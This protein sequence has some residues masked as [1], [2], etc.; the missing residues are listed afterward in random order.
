MPS[1]EEARRKAWKIVSTAA[2]GAAA[3]GW[4]PGSSV[5]LAGGDLATVKLVADAFGVTEYSV[6]QIV[7]T[8]GKGFVG[9]RI[10]YEML[11]FFPAIGWAIKSG[12]AST[13]TMMSGA[14]LIAYMESRSPYM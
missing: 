12:V 2:A 4:L 6:E 1:L 10:A 8:T 3:T 9:K 5:L 11:S 13:M 14:A 7:I